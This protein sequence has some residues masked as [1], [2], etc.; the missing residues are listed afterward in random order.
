MPTQ[1]ILCKALN[2]S[3]L[4]WNILLWKWLRA[5]HDIVF[6]HLLLFVNMTH[7]TRE[8]T[9]CC[10]HTT[11]PPTLTSSPQQPSDTTPGSQTQAGCPFYRVWCW[12]GVFFTVILPKG[13]QWKLFSLSSHYNSWSTVSHAPTVPLGTRFSTYTTAHGPYRMYGTEIDVVK[14]R[15]HLCSSTTSPIPSLTSNPPILIRTAP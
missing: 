12:D 1:C 3:K 9:D 15:A 8:F 7:V 6:N 14:C 5:S 4:K 11:L 2:V 10:C 13:K